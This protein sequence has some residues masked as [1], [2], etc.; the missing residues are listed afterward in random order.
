M[1]GGRRSSP[2]PDVS[3]FL[4]VYPCYSSHF[5][6]PHTKITLIAKA[7]ICCCWGMRMNMRKENATPPCAD[8]GILDNA[9]VMIAVLD[10]KGT[11]TLWNRTAET[12]TG[13][14]RE[15][16][17]GND[18]IWKLF[19]PDKEYRDSV[20]EKITAVLATKKSIENFET[21]LRTRSGTS[22]IILWNTKKSSEQGK[23]R[24]VAA[25]LDI[26]ESRKAELF[27][28][29]VIDNANILIA[30]LEKGTVIVW[31][32]A[33]ETIT[34]YSPGEVI[35]KRDVWKWLYPDTAYRRT[36]T[37]QITE[38]IAK[39]R[40]F[41]DFV[42][43]I[44]TKSGKKKIISWNTRQIGTGEA[45][46]DIAIGLDI[47]ARKEAEDALAS[48]MTEMAMRLKGPVEVIRDNLSD[49][50]HLLREK[51][52]DPDDIA[53]LL[54]GQKKNA[55]KVALNVQEF[56]QAIAEKHQEIPEAYRKFLAGE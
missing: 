2:H 16:V 31:N 3:R 18:G 27:R 24:I 47:T 41:D 39:N 45:G 5:I 8:A 1:Q 44:V 55:E 7:G 46:Q 34:G 40:Y 56:Q 51:K 29:S 26:T 13:Y 32:K 25:G 28:E 54:E 52:L 11:V 22:R 20:T 21:T 15:E 53:L 23:I 30:V 36:L 33:A 4:P 19:Y 17:V 50:S 37:R 10:E 49:M 48:Y 9:L 12:V 42:T 38:I 14:P 35:G 43:E 6:K